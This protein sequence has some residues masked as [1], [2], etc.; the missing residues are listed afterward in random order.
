VRG[1]VLRNQRAAL[2]ATL[3]VLLSLAKG[4][5]TVEHAIVKSA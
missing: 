4:E 1:L 5:A 3:T 2:G